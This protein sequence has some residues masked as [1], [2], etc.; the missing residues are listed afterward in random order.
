MYLYLIY[1]IVIVI[2]GIHINHKLIKNKNQFK[3]QS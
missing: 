3:I 1:Y 2:R